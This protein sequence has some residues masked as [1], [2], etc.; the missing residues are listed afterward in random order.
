MELETSIH[1]EQGQ[2]AGLPNNAT[3][4][5]ATIDLSALKARYADEAMI[6]KIITLCAHGI[7]QKHERVKAIM[8]EIHDQCQGIPLLEYII[9]VRMPLTVRIGY[10]KLSEIM[11]LNPERIRS[12]HAYWE[13]DSANLEIR[14]DSN[15]NPSD[16]ESYTISQ[17][18]LRR[19]RP[20]HKHSSIVTEEVHDDDKRGTTKRV[21]RG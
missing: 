16:I 3:F 14:V 13:E 17:T 19:L 12:I 5:H 20:A 7:A 21:R 6:V 11:L 15:D 10:E 2:L 9:T 8:T 18:Q 1:F 4:H